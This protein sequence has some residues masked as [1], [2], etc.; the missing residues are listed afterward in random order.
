MMPPFQ[1]VEQ[2]LRAAFCKAWTQSSPLLSISF[3]VLLFAYKRFIYEIIPSLFGKVKEILWFLQK[4]FHLRQH[5]TN[6]SSDCVGTS[7]V[8][9][10]LPFRGQKF[11]RFAVPPFPTKPTLLGFG[12]DPWDSFS[13]EIC[14]KTLKYTEYSC[15]FTPFL[16]KN[17]ASD[18]LADLC[19]I[20]LVFG[21][22]LHSMI[23]L[24]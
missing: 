22:A 6:A 2:L 5:R 11:S 18:S 17:L 3:V 4:L 12:G 1:S 15:G 23:S 9:F 14:R 21:C 10:I 13:P 20:A 24:Y 7:F 19:G 16:P 8:S